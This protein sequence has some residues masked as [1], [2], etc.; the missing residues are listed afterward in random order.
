MSTNHKVAN[1]FKKRLHGL[2]IEAIK[3][4]FFPNC[5]AIHTFG[6]QKGIWVYWI[7]KKYG[8]INT[9]YILP[10]KIRINPKAKHVLESFN[11]LSISELEQFTK[12]ENQKHLVQPKPST[13]QNFK[14]QSKF[15]GQA[16]VEAALILPVFLVIIFGFIQLGMAINAEQRLTFATQYAAQVGAITNNDEQITGSLAL[17]YDIDD[18]EIQIQSRD[19]EDN[20]DIESDQ[21]RYGD[22]FDISVTQ[23]RGISIPLID[24]DFLEIK[25]QA[26]ARITCFNNT[27][28]YTCQD[29]N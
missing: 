5:W 22:I 23:A 15:T 9:E 19:D 24:V 2:K 18:L 17:Y 26:S 13:K 20:S 27:T 7:D 25:A 28:P 6:M 21:R 10:N 3:P 1:S 14:I 16:L 12:I 11:V 8:V 29:T 4:L